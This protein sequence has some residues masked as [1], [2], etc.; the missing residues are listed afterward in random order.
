MGSVN[1]IAYKLH[2]KL[3]LQIIILV[4]VFYGCHF[5]VF[6]LTLPYNN[7]SSLSILFLLFLLLEPFSWE[8]YLRETSSTA[9]SPT[10]FKQVA[11][12]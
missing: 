12:H 11:D 4:L 3:C 2:V 1:K 6:S 9:A 10:C 7:L 5:T 8:D